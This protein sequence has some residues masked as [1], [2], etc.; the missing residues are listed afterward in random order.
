MTHWLL[1]AAR[2]AR[3]PPSAGRVKF[4]LAIIAFCVLLYAIEHYFGWPDALT[5]EKALR[6]G[7]RP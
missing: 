3:H 6:R 2:W 4:V 5:P 7:Y 1:R